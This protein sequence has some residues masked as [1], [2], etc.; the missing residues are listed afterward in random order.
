MSEKA[1]II[2]QRKYR[3][4][5]LILGLLLLLPS[6]IQL[7]HVLEGHKHLGCNQNSTHL[8]E[9]NHKCDVLAFHFSAITLSF[10]P[11][12]SAH[13]LIVFEQSNFWHSE[14]FNNQFLTTNFSRGPPTMI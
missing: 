11:P 2:Q 5:G 12:I 8:H 10:N 1:I 7:G 3:F 4:T 6:F 14:F 9:L 13:V